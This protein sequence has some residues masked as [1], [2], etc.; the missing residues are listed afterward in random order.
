MRLI[1]KQKYAI[2]PKQVQRKI[3]EYYVSFHNR[4]FIEKLCVCKEGHQ[5]LNREAYIS[6]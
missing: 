5:A 3:C 1:T 4:S 6:I 2:L